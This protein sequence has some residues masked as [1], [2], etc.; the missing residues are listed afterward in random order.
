VHALHVTARYATCLLDVPSGSGP[1][2]SS[3]WTM[4][5]TPSGKYLFTTNAVQ[6]IVTMYDADTLERRASRTLNRTAAPPTGPID[7]PTGAVMSP[8]GYLLYVLAESGVVVV[9]TTT[10]GLKA[11][12]VPDRALRSLALSA[13]GRRLYALSLDGTM[14]STIDAMTG[15]PI[16][17][18]AVPVA[19]AIARVR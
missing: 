18:I 1:Q 13:D 15:Q 4:A 17:T 5:L 9:D 3:H 7:A 14:L 16:A 12:Y 19:S 10:L 11:Q 8:E 6:R 2:A